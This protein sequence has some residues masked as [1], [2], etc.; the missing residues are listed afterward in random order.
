MHMEGE[1]PLEVALLHEVPLL[2]ELS[3]LAMFCFSPKSAIL[4]QLSLAVCMVVNNFF[5][6]QNVLKCFIKLALLVFKFFLIVLYLE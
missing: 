3:Q 5:V 1:V 6:R 4:H 2:S